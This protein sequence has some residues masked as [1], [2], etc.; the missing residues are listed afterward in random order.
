MVWRRASP[1]SDQ[2]ARIAE[3]VRDAATTARDPGA[4]PA[5]MTLG[6]R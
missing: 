5:V 4:T 6:S 2:L 3:A 1:L